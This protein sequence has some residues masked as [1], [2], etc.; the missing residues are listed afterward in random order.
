MARLEIA[1][2]EF[3]L[4]LIQ[5][6]NTNKDCTLKSSS[7][8]G[9]RISC[10]A[11]FLYPTAIPGGGTFYLHISLAGGITYIS[12]PKRASWYER[13]ITCDSVQALGNPLT[14]HR[15]PQLFGALLQTTPHFI[16]PLYRP[17]TCFHRPP[18]YLMISHSSRSFSQAL[19]AHLTRK[20]SGSFI[21]RFHKITLKAHPKQPSRQESGIQT[22]RK[23]LGVSVWI[24]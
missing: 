16:R 21:S 7:K 5:K 9:H 24:P 11:L 8:L 6:I 19:K 23:C 12:Q 2:P 14:L 15:T 17:I 4:V 13:L 18:P 22:L 1:L 20:V 3:T 10:A